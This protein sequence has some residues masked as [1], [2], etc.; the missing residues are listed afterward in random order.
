MALAGGYRDDGNGNYV[1]EY[2]NRDRE[3]NQDE[4]G[5]SADTIPHVELAG[6]EEY[7]GMRNTGE[8]ARER[9]VEDIQKEESTQH[10][11]PAE[12]SAGMDTIQED[13][14][15]D[16]HESG[17]SHGAHARPPGSWIV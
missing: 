11:E 12:I 1:K 16:D 2:D 14:A 9:E 17:S 7:L 5:G 15:E 8:D 4:E 3:T 13:A 6:A 10:V